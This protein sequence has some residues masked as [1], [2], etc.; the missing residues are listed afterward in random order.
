MTAFVVK[1]NRDC[2]CRFCGGR[3]DPRQEFVLTVAERPE[4]NFNDAIETLHLTCYVERRARKVVNV[5][6]E[7]GDL[8]DV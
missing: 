6:N 1:Y 7:T 8:A 2:N 3:I 5:L 4:K